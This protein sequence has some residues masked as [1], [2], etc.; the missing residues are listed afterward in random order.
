[1]LARTV[2]AAVRQFRSDRAYTGHV[3]DI[4]DAPHMTL[5]RVRQEAGKE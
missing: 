3:F 4:I 2:I 5:L 1:M